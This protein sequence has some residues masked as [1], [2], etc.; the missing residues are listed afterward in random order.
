MSKVLQQL[1]CITTDT[2]WKICLAEQKPPVLIRITAQ[3]HFDTAFGQLLP[4]IS[5]E[6]FGQPDDRVVDA[7]FGSALQNG[8]KNIQSKGG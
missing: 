7:G 8:A 4:R 5:I 1:L 6:S 3:R 2:S